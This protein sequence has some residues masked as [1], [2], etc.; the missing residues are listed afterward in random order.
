MDKTLFLL[1]SFESVPWTDLQRDVLQDIQSYREM[2]VIFRYKLERSCLRK[3]F[4]IGAFHSGIYSSFLIRQCLNTV[5]VK[6]K[7][8]HFASHWRLWWKV[9]YPEI[10][11][12]RK[13]S[14]KLRSDVCIHFRELKFALRCSVWKLCLRRICEG[15]LSGARS[16][17]VR[18]EMPSDENWTE[19]FG[20]TALQCVYAFQRIKSYFG[21]SSLKSMFLWNLRKNI[22]ERS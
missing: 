2:V 16:L 15:I 10:K 5:A 19:S 20:V 14:R 17:V 9:K 1:R 12:R 3:C 13:D 7:K 22:W 11:P 8:W 18:N 4:E 6:L 21:L